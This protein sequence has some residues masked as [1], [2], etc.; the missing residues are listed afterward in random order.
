MKYT[1]IGAILSS[2]VTWIFFKNIIITLI[3]LAS[4]K[5]YLLYK[6]K[7]IIISRK[8]EL[9]KQFVDFLRSLSDAL[10]TGNSLEKSI[11]LTKIDIEK[12]Y[13]RESYMYIEN[14]LISNKIKLNIPIEKSM[15]DLAMRTGIKEII[16]FSEII[17]ISK[18]RGGNMIKMISDCADTLTNIIETKKEVNT[19]IAGKVNEKKIMDKIPLVIIM[20]ISITSPEIMEP[21]YTTVFGRIVMIIALV[22]YIF[23]YYLGERIVD[24]KV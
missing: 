11:E 5:F 1:L 6:N 15:D 22:G 12:L 9:Q 8:E 2:L 24:I 23:A 3:G 21:L 16:H 7:T 10:K 20:Y 4:V 13:G 17:K 14:L 19:I 18:K